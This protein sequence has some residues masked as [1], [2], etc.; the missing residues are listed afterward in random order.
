M[1]GISAFSEAPFSS[2]ASGNG[3]FAAFISENLSITDSLFATALN[4]A[5]IYE[6]LTATDATSRN[7]NCFVFENSAPSDSLANR[8]IFNIPLNESVN[9]T[10]SD[11]TS[12]VFLPSVDELVTATDSPV[13]NISIAVYIVEYNQATDTFEYGFLWI[14]IESG[15]VAEWEIINNQQ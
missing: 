2:T 10:D 5:F 4:P 13:G 1:F 12:G 6:S 14:L 7:T 15:Q 9:A 8:F 11:S 3:N